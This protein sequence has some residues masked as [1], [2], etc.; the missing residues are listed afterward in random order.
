LEPL[1]DSIGGL[2]VEVVLLFLLFGPTELLLLGV[3]QGTVFKE[4]GDGLC[5]WIQYDW[6]IAC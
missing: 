5:F 6:V 1:Q 3:G 4:N 2:F